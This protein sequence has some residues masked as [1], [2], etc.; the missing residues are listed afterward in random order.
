MVHVLQALAYQ[1]LGRWYEDI[2]QD[3]KQAQHCYERAVA[4][5]DDDIIAGKLLGLSAQLYMHAACGV[6]PRGKLRHASLGGW[7][8]VR[9]KD[10]LRMCSC[11]CAAVKVLC[12]FHGLGF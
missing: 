2:D 10:L 8:L 9:H 1:W 11:D 3:Y 4:L 12:C 6:V 5:D 7:R